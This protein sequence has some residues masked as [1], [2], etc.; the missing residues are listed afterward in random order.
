MN[1][2]LQCSVDI[3]KTITACILNLKIGSVGKKEWIPN[4]MFIFPCKAVWKSVK[5]LLC[6]ILWGQIV[7]KQNHRYSS[8]KEATYY[9]MLHTL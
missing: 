3:I 2:K 8:H 7:Y 1:C 9:T 4:Q 5:K 6:S